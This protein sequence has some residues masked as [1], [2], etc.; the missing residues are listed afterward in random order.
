MEGDKLARNQQI[1]GGAAA[2]T[3]LVSV[4]VITYNH[5]PFIAQCLDGIVRQQTNFSFELIVHDDASTD[6]TADI[7]RQYA[8]EYPDVIISILQEENQWL[9]GRAAPHIL[10]KVNGR[11]M[12]L[13][14]GDDYWSDPNKL[15]KQVGILEANKEY[16]LCFHNVNTHWE[17]GKSEDRLVVDSNVPSGRFTTRHVIKNSPRIATCSMV[18]RTEWMYPAPQWCQQTS[19]RDKASQLILS[20]RGDIFYISD[21]MSV[22]RLNESSV[23]KDY[24]DFDRFKITFGLF[25]LFNGYTHGRYLHNMAWRLVSFVCAMVLRSAK[26]VVK[27]VLQ[28]FGFF[29]EDKES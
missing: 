27:A 16:S 1:A 3:P 24:T 14:E 18:F 4:C 23:S 10:P 7:V 6:G 22:Y 28:I 25:R 26:A 17:N 12:A 13:C 11:Y 2:E 21:V 20:T 8:E 5:A 29:A 19:A 15:Q 9:K